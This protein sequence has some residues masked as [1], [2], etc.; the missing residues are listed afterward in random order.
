MIQKY[1]HLLK[2]F[3][4]LIDTMFI[5]SFP[6]NKQHKCKWQ[7][8]LHFYSTFNWLNSDFLKYF[9][10]YKAIIPR[11]AARSILLGEASYTLIDDSGVEFYLS[12]KDKKNRKRQGL[13][14]L[15]KRRVTILED[16]D[17][18]PEKRKVSE[19]L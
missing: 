5:C 2:H 11:E 6:Y 10:F 18:V 4:F 1:R 14:D 3:S 12:P 9:C 8:T 13:E 7:S 17:E 15:P 16:G 19:I